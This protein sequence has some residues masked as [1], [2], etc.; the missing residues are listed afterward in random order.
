MSNIHPLCIC[1]T[2]HMNARCD[3]SL[4]MHT[5]AMYTSVYYIHIY[6]HTRAHALT[7]SHAHNITCA[8]ACAC[9]CTHIDTCKA[10]CT[11]HLGTRLTHAMTHDHTHVH[12]LTN[13]HAHAHT[14][15]HTHTHC[16]Q[17]LPLSPGD[18]SQ[19]Q[20]SCPNQEAAAPLSPVHDR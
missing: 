18:S 2:N 6:M 5:H 1:S 17:V 20:H 12:T 13:T 16:T 9:T 3:I 7:L 19:V 15:A 10:S 8:N 11:E 4:R 14:H